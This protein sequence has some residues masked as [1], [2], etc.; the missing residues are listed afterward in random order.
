MNTA[1]KLQPTIWTTCARRSATT[2]LHCTAAPMVRRPR[3]FTRESIPLECAQCC[4]KASQR[5]TSWCRCLTRA[6]PKARWSNSSL[7][8][9]WI[10]K[11][12]HAFPNFAQHFSALLAHFNSGDLPV[13]LVQG[14]AERRLMLSREVFVDRLRQLLYD[15]ATA[16]IVP[17][18][19]EEAYRG[20]HKTAGGSNRSAH[21]V[22]RDS[23]LMGHGDVGQLFGR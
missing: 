13:T 17:F 10:A 18:I 15:P 3:R 11:C 16:S 4:L 7:C 2:K 1:R 9:A 14:K 23:A 20:Q 22:V 6:A 21:A 8:A 12:H 19:I 5:R